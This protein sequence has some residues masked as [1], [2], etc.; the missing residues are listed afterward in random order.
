[1][2]NDFRSRALAYGREGRVIVGLSAT[3]PGERRPSLVAATVQGHQRL[4][5]VAFYP[6]SGW[7]CD[8][9]RLKPCPHIAAVALVTGQP[10]LA[11][12]PEQQEAPATTGATTS[13]T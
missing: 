10:H 8:C 6:T 13:T 9:I 11:G 1:M 2:P 5:R 3:L 7:V 4:H 12:R